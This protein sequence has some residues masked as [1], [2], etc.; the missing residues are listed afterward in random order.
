MKSINDFKT[1]MQAHGYQ[2]SQP[3]ADG[4]IHRAPAQGDRSTETSWW[5]ILFANSN[6]LIGE[7]GNWRTGLHDKWTSKDL[8]RLSADE[9][10][11]LDHA[12]RQAHKARETAQ[13]ALQRDCRLKA[14]QLWKDAPMATPHHPYLK[15]KGIQAFG[16][17]Q[18][19]RT[20]T[21]IVPVWDGATKAE[22]PVLAGLQFIR[23]DGTKKFMTGTQKKGGYYTIGNT[24]SDIQVICEGYATGAS[25]AQATGYKVTIAFD[26]GNLLAVAQHMASEATTASHI[27]IAGDNDMWSHHNI[28][29]EKARAASQ[30]IGARLAMP[31]FTGLNTAQKPTDFNDLHQ[32]AG[33]EEVARQIMLAV[34]T[35]EPEPPHNIAHSATQ[36]VTNR[37]FGVETVSLDQIKMEPIDWLM[38]NW[39]PLGK[40]TLLAGQAGTGKTQLAIS[41]ASM[42]S[43]GRSLPDG[44]THPP[45][46]TLMWTGEDDIATV[47]T[48]RFKAAHAQ[49]ER[50]H[51]VQGVKDAKGQQ[52]PFD[53]ALD[54][55]SLKERALEIGDI[56]LMIIDPLVSVVAGDSNKASDV[57]A[58]LHPIV[59]MAHTLNC[60]ILGITHYRK[61]NLSNNVSDDVLG[62]QAYIAVPRVAWGTKRKDNDNTCVVAIIKNNLAPVMGGYEYEIES[63][64][65]TNDSGPDITTSR[66]AWGEYRAETANQLFKELSGEDNDVMSESSKFLIE[67]LKDGTSRKVSEIKQLIEERPTMSWRSVERSANALKV[68]RV[69]THSFPSE[70]FWSLPPI[71]P[72]LVKQIA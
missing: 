49:M 23:A 68:A 18:F 67:L 15:R 22:Q 14:I 46:N 64:V 2:G 58:G 13:A 35:P 52:R 61:G 51:L 55:P 57:R 32:L 48:P 33:L 59:D 63:Q 6:L 71:S 70:T 3:I 39:L 12:T 34:P 21:L 26:A 19:G 5:Y 16:C 29:L 31:D 45:L 17:K 7:F 25:I 47:I 1:A 62:S 72:Y 8:N 44:T 11:A 56:G 30:A 43:A 53:F 65:L 40:L 27:I 69:R 37:A 66:I 4:K 50:I 24:R 9:R 28:G 42:L 20:D 38:H 41:L 54:L 10:T 36:A 60:A